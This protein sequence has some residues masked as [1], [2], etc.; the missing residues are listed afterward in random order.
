MQIMWYFTIDSFCIRFNVNVFEAN[1][2]M[3]YLSTLLHL[4]LINMAM[5]CAHLCCSEIQ[6]IE[7]MKLFG[8]TGHLPVVRRHKRN[9]G[10]G[11]KNLASRNH[12]HGNIL[13]RI[14]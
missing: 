8:M 13:L 14:T 3:V 9:M 10:N 1:N 12:R 5:T 4:R 7:L 6:E 2:N 11:L